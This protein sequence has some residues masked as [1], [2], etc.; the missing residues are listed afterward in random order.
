MLISIRK[1]ISGWVAWLVVIIIAVPFAL[2]G[3]NAYFE[4]VNQVNVANVAGEKISLQS[5]LQAS[6]RRKQFFR[7]QFGAG[8]DTS[9]FDTPEARLSIVEE[10]VINQAEQDFV[11]D[12][13]LTLNNAAL[14]QRIVQTASF[15][16]DGQFNQDTYRRILS[17]SGYSTEGYEQQQRIAGATQQLRSGLVDSS[18]INESEVDHILKLNLQQRDAD[19]L[20][21]ESK[22]LEAD[23]QISDDEISEEYQ[24]NPDAYQQEARIKVDYLE[25]NVEDMQKDVEPAE[26][27]LVQ[28]YENAKGRYTQPETRQAS[29][30][31]LSVAKSA[32]EEKR[33]GIL[34]KAQSVFEQAKGGADFAV[35]A[36]E[37]SEDPGSSKKGGDLGI[38]AKGQMVASFEE[39]VFS[40]AADE[41][42]G[43][44]ETQF[45][46]HII[47]LTELREE[48]QKAF[49]EVIDQ[50]RTA[51]QKRLA[52]EQF[53]EIAETFRILVIEQPDDLIEASES[54]GLEIKTSDWITQRSGTALFT[55]ANLRTAAFDV[56]VLEDNFNSE[57]VEMT[58]GKLVAMHK[59]EY[60]DAHL[61]ALDEVKTQITDQLRKKR[62]SD[63]AAE[64]GKALIADIQA[65]SELSEDQAALVKLLPARKDD[66]SDSVERELGAP[67]FSAMAPTEGETQ[68]DGLTLNNGDYAVFRLRS[69][70]LGDPTTA[71]EEQR[72]QVVQQLNQRDGNSSY[73]LFRS[74]LRANTDVEIFDFAFQ[75]DASNY[76]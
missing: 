28:A 74:V 64:Q 63:E 45:G 72:N 46:Y 30:I 21:I 6:E 68:I 5:F 17:A 8:F 31:L 69:V 25:L 59:N 36:E 33:A 75:D 42:R 15:Q 47:K 3:I 65:G 48:R 4:G 60:E 73:T 16:E 41:I 20:I 54:L 56:A 43:P 10:L 12:N 2:F 13:G 40:M 27:E 52:D 34:A 44:I 24:S 26:E 76:N 49:D 50:V 1:K 57:V 70:T 22:P 32:S 35:L 38:V 19:Y 11:V 9:T 23:I 29:H 71:T 37:H 66:A 61:K 62:A 18:F 55:N 7:S 53:V 39:A 58:D 67:V 14:Q 51:E